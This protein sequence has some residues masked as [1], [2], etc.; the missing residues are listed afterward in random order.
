MKKLLRLLSGEAITPPP[1]WLMR[2]AGRYL[3]EYRALRQQA[4]S[5]LGLCFNPELAAEVTL[6]PVTRFG[7]DAAILF[8]DILVVPYALGQALDYR[9][10]EGPVLDPVTDERG[11]A[12]LSLAALPERL[13][14]IY[15][16]VRRVAAAQ[17][18]ECTLIGFAGGPW[19]VAAYMMEGRG[20]G[21][22]DTARRLAYAAPAFV[23]RLIDLVTEATIEYLAAQVE[24]GAEALQL[25]DSWAGLL[26]A[27]QF[28]L[29]VIKPTQRVTAA[30]KARYPFIRIIGFP[31]GAGYSY[32]AYSSLAG[33]DALGLDTSVPLTAV[34]KT[35]AL[36]PMPLQGNLDPLLL[37]EGGAALDNGI[38]EIKRLMAGYPHIFNLGHGVSQ[39]TNPDHVAR[40]V[41]A[42]K[43]C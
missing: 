9:E 34:L 2:Q 26:T 12:A 13:G 21:D 29:Y 11:L 27:E 4:G 25:F 7:M 42:V 18:P 38:A 8:S 35:G 1:V 5:F 28:R 16:T 36:T 23:Q 10:G 15:E 31:R 24:A 37:L 19:T 43:N 17:P 32:A 22:F 14:P 33:V 20:G 40:L 30:L 41:E 3:P 6:Q 39:H